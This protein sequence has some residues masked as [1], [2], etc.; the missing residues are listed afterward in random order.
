[1]RVA[2]GV[3]GCGSGGF[4]VWV[5]GPEGGRPGV[6][7]RRMC[8]WVRGIDGPAS[9][10]CRCGDTP[11]RP[12]SG[13]PPLPSVPPYRWSSRD[14][15][16]TDL[17]PGPV[18]HSWAARSSLTC[19]PIAGSCAGPGG[20]AARGDVTVRARLA[21]LCGPG[22]CAGMAQ[23]VRGSWR[24][25]CFGGD[26]SCVGGA[27]GGV[28]RAGGAVPGVPA[29]TGA[30][31][32]PTSARTQGHMRRGDTPVRTLRP[33]PP[34]HP[35]RPP[36]NPRPHRPAT[37]RRA[38]TVRGRPPPGAGRWFPPRVWRRPPRLPVRP[39]RA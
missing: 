31:R 6:S 10:T 19:R 24:C 37:P 1:M 15:D 9:G 23:A 29:A 28:R 7:P 30:G 20:R 13:R 2:V 34:T 36:A 12:P 35:N 25:G 32:G 39:R 16:T 5:V 3:R 26:G 22:W 4:G 14:G 38:T 21:C 33:P 11:G 27:V 17:R 8:P 18:A